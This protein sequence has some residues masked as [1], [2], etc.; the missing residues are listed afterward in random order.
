VILPFYSSLNEG[1]VENL[2]HVMNFDV[3]KAWAWGLGFG[4]RE[5]G[6]WGSGSRV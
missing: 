3:P 1:D 6:I 2:K 4:G 5:F